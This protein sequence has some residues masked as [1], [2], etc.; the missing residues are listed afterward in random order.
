V[1]IKRKRGNNIANL[2]ETIEVLPIWADLTANAG[3]AADGRY[4]CQNI[5]AKDLFLYES[6]TIPSDSEIGILVPEHEYIGLLQIGTEL[7]FWARI[8]NDDPAGQSGRL[9]ISAIA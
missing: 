9:V 8:N 4:I 6:D 1:A 2:T 3:L 7:R 5:G